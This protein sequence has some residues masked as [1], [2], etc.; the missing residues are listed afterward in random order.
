MSKK[1]NIDG[2]IVFEPNAYRLSYDKGDLRLSQK[3]SAV[4]LALC[5]NHSRVVERKSLLLNIWDERESSDISLNKNILLLR[6][7]FESI[8]LHNAIETVPRVGYILKLTVDIIDETSAISINN[9]ILKQTDEEIKADNIELKLT[10]GSHRPSYTIHSALTVLTVLFV[11]CYYIIHTHLNA[12]KSQLEQIPVIYEHQS[13]T[14]ERKLFYT[15]KD[16]NKHVYATFIDNISKS[17]TFF[18]LISK[19]ALSYIEFTPKGEILWQKVFIFD[20][21]TD[22][23]KQS[24]CIAKFINQYAPSHRIDNGTSGMVL[25]RLKF[26]HYC[27]IDTAKSIGDL[28]I[29]TVSSPSTIYNKVFIQNF[30]FSNEK[31]NNIFDFKRITRVRGKEIT[32]T[33]S[34]RDDY[35]ANLQLKSLSIN[36][37]NDIILQ[38]DPDAMRIFE[39]FTQDKI[40]LTTIDDQKDIYATSIFGGVI[41]HIKRFNE[42]KIINNE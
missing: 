26:Y 34:I 17:K 9:I 29:M 10:A 1:F 25:A 36:Y 18:S 38:K 28:S 13:N 39:E 37:V 32:G 21:K 3:E 20:Q 14:P 41:Y 15:N 27:K 4:L 8:G 5:E 35:K 19:S 11:I 24:K 6:R 31:N 40:S 7:K 12:D 42:N 30:N 2:W 23:V 33:D 22:L 16:F